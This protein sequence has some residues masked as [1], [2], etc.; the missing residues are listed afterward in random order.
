MTDPIIRTYSNDPF[1][2]AAMG[3]W[4]WKNPPAGVAV[5][6]INVGSDEPVQIHIDLHD[7][8]LRQVTFHEGT[9][10]VNL[11]DSGP[12]EQI[13]SPNDTLIKD[14]DHLYPGAPPEMVVRLH[15]VVQDLLKN[16]KTIQA[17]KE[18]RGLTNLG[19]KEAKDIVDAERQRLRGLGFDTRSR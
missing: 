7:D 18:M 3:D 14:N 15:P 19:L 10:T 13:A 6:L 17:I 1:T 16:G 8:S 9:V 12:P 2:R 11:P 5:I 4:R